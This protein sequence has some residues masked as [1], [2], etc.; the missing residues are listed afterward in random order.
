MER[1]TIWRLIFALLFSLASLSASFA[2]RPMQE[3]EETVGRVLAILRAY[4]SQDGDRL[5]ER[6][7]KLLQAIL[8][9]FDFRE[10]AK[11]SLGSHWQRQAARQEEFV[12]VFTSFVEHAYVSQIESYK[13]Q[14]VLFTRERIDNSFAQVETK[15]VPSQGAEIP[16]HYRLHRVGGSWK[17]YD[18]VI[19]NISLVNNYRSQFNR[20]L[21]S[22]SFDE[23][24]ERLR[25]KDGRE[26]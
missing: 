1:K 17:V 14:K 23:L 3:V 25:S 20:I 2:D 6:R 5:R 21:S 12:S 19:E 9:R 18:V 8:P 4:K 24:L 11:R 22:A 26:S 7:E 10:M 15:I 16:I 13:D